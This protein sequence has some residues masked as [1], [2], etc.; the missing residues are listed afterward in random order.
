MFDV[1]DQLAAEL[2]TIQNAI[3]FIEFLASIKAQEKF[4]KENFEYPV[5]INAK[6]SDLL[7]S[8]GDFKEDTTSLYKVGTKNKEA[9][10]IFNKV[11]WD[12]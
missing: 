4:A 1:L 7:K 8:W 3:K 5:N 11:G 9:V 12:K 6:T 10:K 2:E